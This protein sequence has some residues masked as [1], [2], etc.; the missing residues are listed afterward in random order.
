MPWV[1]AEGEKP[2]LIIATLEAL[3]VLVSLRAFY[4]REAP[5]GRTRVTVAP[6]WIDNRVHFGLKNTTKV[7]LSEAVA[8]GKVRRRKTNTSVR[9]QRANCQTVRPRTKRRNP[10]DK[11]RQKDP[12]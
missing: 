2:A 4:G 6:I 1:Y 8:M 3:A 5:D 11:L 12:W 10:E 9:R 7:I